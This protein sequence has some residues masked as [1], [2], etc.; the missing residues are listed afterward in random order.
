MHVTGFQFNSSKALS[1]AVDSHVDSFTKFIYN[2]KKIPFL[3]KY[4]MFVLF[5]D[6]L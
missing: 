5:V 1:R 6:A 2:F 4:S 3:I